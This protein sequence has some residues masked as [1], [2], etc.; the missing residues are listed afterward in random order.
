MNIAIIGAGALG[1]LFGGVLER[2]GETVWLVHH[3]PEVARQ[4]DEAGVGIESDDFSVDGRIPINATADASDIGHADLVVVLT[5]TYQTRD[6]LSTH[7]ACI[8][9]ET[10]LLTL[11]NGL[12]LDRILAEFVPEERVL[13]GVTYMGASRR[14]SGAIDHTNSGKTVFG[15]P[16][17]TFAED[18][19]A[20][21]RDAGLPDVD[22]VS[23][24]RPEIWDKQLVSVAFKPTAALTRLPNGEL[25]D[26]DF[27]SPLME[28]LVAEA[29]R[30]A[31]ARGVTIPS[32][33]PFE[34]VR[35]I[36]R[37][38][39]TH[40]SSMLQDVAARRQTEIMEA[41]GAI[42]ELAEQEGIEVPYNRAVTALVHGLELSYRD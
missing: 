28:A 26:D 21:F 16:D 23:D 27:V 22:A 15:G 39:P 8:G 34:R 13:A 20:R 30:V 42:V 37:S 18:V 33:D 4:L 17:E 14:S 1:I 36:G 25:V 6:A 24:P 29:E 5:K 7:E 41:N 38:N 19:A 10:R 40:T 35:S 3:D 11:Q 2:N 32:N 12:T 9:P 31:R